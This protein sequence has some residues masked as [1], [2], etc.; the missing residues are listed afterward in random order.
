MSFILTIGHVALQ[1]LIISAVA[2]SILLTIQSVYT[3]YI[4]LYT[5]DRPEA[6]QMAKAPTQFLTPRKSFTVLLPAR[7]EEDVIQTTIERVVHANYP[8]SLLEVVVICSIDDTGTIGKAQ[9]KIAQL[10]RRG[11]NNVRVLA[12]KNKPINKPHGLNVGLRS[13]RNEVVT[14]FDSEDDIHP[15]IFNVMNTV[16]LREKVAVVQGGVQL[17]NYQS[18]WYSVLN[19]LEYFFWFKSRLH[20]HARLGMTPLGG[21]TVFFTREVLLRVGGWDE[22]DL[23][24]DA[25]IGIRLSLLGERMRVIYDDRYVTR[26][27]TPPTLSQFIKQRTRWSQGFLQTL[28]K[29]DWKQLPRFGQRL[30]ALYTLGFPALQAVLGFYIAASII[31]MFTLKVP[32]VLAMIMDLPFYL[33]AAHLLLDVI[34]LYEFTGA[35]GLKPTWKTPLTMALGYL[36]YQWVLA[37]ASMRATVR[38]LRGIN[39]WEKTR[40]IGAHRQAEAL[41]APL[42]PQN[43]RQDEAVSS[44]SVA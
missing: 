41:G 20:Y 14:I 34:G 23:T 10:R 37:Y 35:H 16:M 12:F 4:M 6:Y 3:L 26:E 22:Y 15:D 5:W 19:V 17:M 30:L 44:R 7:H 9:Q 40:H 42:P 13:T 43:K 24:E 27:E 18:K 38:H 33:L 2:L 11:I 29:G 1:G 36:P 39:N 21:N 31:M 28:L 25:D 8:S 32:V